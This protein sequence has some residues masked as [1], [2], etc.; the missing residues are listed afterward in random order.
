MMFS[1]FCVE[2]PVSVSA[3]GSAPIN[4]QARTISPS[5]VVVQWHEPEEANGVIKVSARAKSLE[6]KGHSESVIP[7]SNQMA[8]FMAM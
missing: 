8:Q 7:L 5:T 6:V 2:S 1:P 3:P 4:I